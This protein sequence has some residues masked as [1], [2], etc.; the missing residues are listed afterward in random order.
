MKEGKEWKNITTCC[1]WPEILK[2]CF[3]EHNEMKKKILIIGPTPPPIGGVS[4]HVE[5]LLTVLRNEFDVVYINLRKIAFKDLKKVFNARL[6]HINISNVNIIFILTFIFKILGKKSIITIHG[7][8]ERIGRIKFRLLLMT[9]RL[10]SKIIVL[11]NS[12]QQF[13]HKHGLGNVTKI[14]AF[15]PPAKINKLPIN[16][17]RSLIQKK[18]K[19]KYLF[20]TNAWRAVFDKDGTET[21]GIIG[22]LEIFNGLEY[23]L[24]FSD[25]SASYSLKI[26]KEKIN[27]PENV[28]LITGN[29]D[30]NA[31]LQL[32][33][34]F[35]RTTSTDGDSLSVREAL[36]LGKPV[37]AS[38]VVDRPSGV[39]LYEYGNK[40]S[41]MKNI[42]L[43]AIGGVILKQ[44]ITSS[45]TIED[46]KELYNKVL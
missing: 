41:L 9:S 15:I 40:H 26:N 27:I 14:S 45:T 43:I 37:L 36:Y 5:R 11:N 6:I 10:C 7:N 4:I 38:D 34:A 35:L 19:Y 29:H 25:P 39:I 8:V 24:V 28:Y 32:C 30:F 3:P 31:V 18:M 33:D 20:C 46:I 16:L 22:L 21:Y 12:S 42:R 2:N 13:L 1:Q 17:E 23:G 44:Q